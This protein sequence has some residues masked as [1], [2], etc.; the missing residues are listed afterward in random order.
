MTSPA[1]SSCGLERAVLV[2]LRSPRGE[3]QLCVECWA[4]GKPLI[5]SARK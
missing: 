4:P 1:C 2:V 5:R 3:Y